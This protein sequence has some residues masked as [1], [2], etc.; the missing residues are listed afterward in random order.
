MTEAIAQVPRPAPSSVESAQGTAW[1][2]GSVTVQVSVPVGVTPGPDTVA[3]NVKLPPV[4]PPAASLLI[5]IVVPA[6]PTVAVSE[7]VPLL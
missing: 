7:P 3:V 1:P 6:L 5:V 4:L 2:R